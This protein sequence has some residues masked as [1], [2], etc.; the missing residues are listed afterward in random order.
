M[1]KLLV[2][3][4]PYKFNKFIDNLLEIDEF[5]K[6][7]NVDIWDLRSI[8]GKQDSKNSYHQ[9]DT[10]VNLIPIKSILS[11][12]ANV[13]KLRHKSNNTD[14]VYILNELNYRTPSQLLCNMILGFILRKSKVRAVELANGGM[15]YWYESTDTI[16]R[17][18]EKSFFQKIYTM[19][20]EYSIQFGVKTILE[21]LSA[22]LG[23]QSPSITTHILVAGSQSQCI[24]RDCGRTVKMVMGHTQDYSNALLDQIE[25]KTKHVAVNACA[26]VIYLDQG[27]PAFPI[28]PGFGIPNT[29]TKNIW[30]P[31]LNRFFNFLEKSQN[32][33]I[34]IAGHYKT[35][36]DFEEPLFEMRDVLYGHTKSLIRNCGFVIACYS[37][38]I[39]YAVIFR[40]P[41]IFI[42][43]DEYQSNSHGMRHIFGLAAMLGKKPINIEHFSDSISE[44]LEIDEDRYGYYERTVLTSGVS[45]RPNVQII[46]EDVMGIDTEQEYTNVIPPVFAAG[47][48]L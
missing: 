24:A 46:L 1:N 30:Y 45:R 6:F 5:R 28:D 27:W 20:A 42:Y 31:A 10:E 13:I 26:E 41:I 15:P 19:F 29:L 47:F 14:D 7:I 2:V 22:S 11:F 34:R 39:S 44:Y 17:R 35:N 16:N 8:T 48:T 37:T 21:Y 43:T 33:R 18:S 23:K 38:S 32:T 25:L 3:L 40:K 9:Y 12:I 4:Y 36:Y